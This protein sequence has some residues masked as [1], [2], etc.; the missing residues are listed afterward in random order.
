MEGAGRNR[1]PPRPRQCRAPTWAGGTRRPGRAG[2]VAHALRPLRPGLVEV[3]RPLVLGAL[4][5]RLGVLGCQVLHGAPVPA[6]TTRGSPGRTATVHTLGGVALTHPSGSR[7]WRQRPRAAGVARRLSCLALSASCVQ[8]VSAAQRAASI[9]GVNGNSGVI[10]WC[11][12]SGY[13]RPALRLITPKPGALSLKSLPLLRVSTAVESSPGVVQ[14]VQKLQCPLIFTV[15]PAPVGERL[16]VPS[17]L[18]ATCRA[19]SAG[20][21]SSLL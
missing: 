1:R 21:E 5:S 15:G 14:T 7:S 2:G 11:V 20:P 13:V 17:R 12:P 3:E 4:G 19:A 18:A 16:Q 8:D 10:P 9:S 6:L